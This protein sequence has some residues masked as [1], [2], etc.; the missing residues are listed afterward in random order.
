MDE[1][2]NSLL[3]YHGH[4]GGGSN[5]SSNVG[6]GSGS[7]VGAGGGINTSSTLAATTTSA[8]PQSALTLRLAKVCDEVVAELETERAALADAQA[9]LLRD[10][11][12]WAAFATHLDDV[13]RA[14]SEKVTL[15]VGGQLFVTTVSTLRRVH[16]SFFAQMFS[17]RWMIPGGSSSSNNNSQHSGGESSHS[18]SSSSASS[19]MP[20]SSEIFI[21]R[22]PTMFRHMYVLFL[23]VYSSLNPF[24]WSSF[25][26]LSNPSYF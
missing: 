17:G 22:D 16:D 5:S 12:A 9:A 14:F 7:G 11:E 21:D 10:K 4:G 1:S 19:A 26:S 2:N 25:R 15:N 3:G 18:S 23:V 24:Y 20:S 13:N 8:E 6:N